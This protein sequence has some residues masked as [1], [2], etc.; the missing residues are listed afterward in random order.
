MK[1]LIVSL[2]VT[3]ALMMGVVV[4][5]AGYAAAQEK[6]TLY[7]LSHIGPADPNMRWL[8]IAIEDFMKR[9]PEVEV[10]YVA[11]E[12]FSIKQ[13]VEDVETAIAAGA[14]GLIVPITD[15]TAL[16][17]VLRRAVDA[18]IPV[19]AANI[20]DPRPAPEK[21]PYLTYV[22]GD[23]Y[24][25]GVKLG[26][27]L[28]QAWRDGR[29]PKPVKVMVPIHHVGHIGLEY[30]AK[31]MT[32]AMKEIGVPVEKLA[33]GDEPTKAKQIMTS[34]LS[35]NPDVNVIFCVAA[36]S[37]PWA[38]EVA[39]DLELDPDV[40]NKGVT[41]LCVDASPVALEGIIAGKVLATHSQG[42][43]LQG[44][45]PPEWLY[46]YLHFGYTPPPEIITGPIIIDNTNVEKW[47]KLVMT[48]FGEKTYK[49][50]VL[51]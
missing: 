47:K 31:G 12:T 26:Q 37:A 6:Y 13:Q 7:F 10:R 29:L 40:D 51:W 44:Y 1:K 3:L 23:E 22:G 30:R 39:S 11:T 24:L 14:D 33:I 5:Q 48:V 16:E 8:T 43:Y 50:L 27:N 9:Y 46:F 32:D 49:E 42:F 25:V 21:I 15:P 2:L 38:Y 35:V 34:Y 36:W 17:D 28:L 4:G 19:V 18:G 45:L 41:I 20:C